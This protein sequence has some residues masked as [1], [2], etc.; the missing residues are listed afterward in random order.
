[1]LALG[2]NYELTGTKRY[3]LGAGAHWV[4]RCVVKNRERK[5]GRQRDA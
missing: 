1:M 2:W 5:R 4:L 3:L